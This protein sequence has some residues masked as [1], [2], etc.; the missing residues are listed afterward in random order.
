MTFNINYIPDKYNSTEELFESFDSSNN[1]YDFID[2]FKMFNTANAKYDLNEESIDIF[3]KK[4]DKTSKFYEK[5]KISNNKI[6]INKILNNDLTTNKLEVNNNFIKEE[7]YSTIITNDITPKLKIEYNANELDKNKERHYNTKSMGR[8]KG[9]ENNGNIENFSIHDKFKEDNMRIKFKRAFFNYLINFINILI[10][11]SPKLKS[12]G[13]LQKLTLTIMNR[14]KKD[15]ILKMLDLTAGEFLSQNNS[16]KQKNI[17][18]DHNKN[19]IKSI[20]QLNEINV[21][22]ILN[23]TV[24]EL[25]IIFCN[26]KKENDSY[27]H[28]K[29]LQDYIDNVLILKNHQNE[30]YINKFKHQACNYEREYIKLDGRKEKN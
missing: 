27:I 4:N 17:S 15:Y 23:K 13:K 19:V 16:Q 21:I 14:N 10:G 29:R 3:E 20:Y 25:M 24:R 8:K 26:D 28:F 12:I 7:K 5:E 30:N 1:N 6:L 18:K 22:K 11:K 9:S 2:F